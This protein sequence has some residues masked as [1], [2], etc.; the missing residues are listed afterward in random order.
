MS[1][2]NQC[3]NGYA[4][5]VP[6]P[7]NE[8]STTSEYKASPVSEV[9]ISSPQ[10]KITASGFNGY[11][12]A[13][14]SSEPI[15][16][17]GDT[18]RATEQACKPRFKAPTWVTGAM[19]ALKIKLSGWDESGNS[20]T[21]CGSGYIRVVDGEAF[22]EDSLTLNADDLYHESVNGLIG[23]PICSDHIAVSDE[24]GKVHSQKP[25]QGQMSVIVGNGFTSKWCQMD[26]NE[27][28]LCKKGVLEYVDEIEEIGFASPTMAT[29]NGQNQPV[30]IDPEGTRCIKALCGE[31]ISITTKVADP[32]YSVGC[33]SSNCGEDGFRYVTKRVTIA[34]LKA[35]LESA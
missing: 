18:A 33:A 34:E 3:E 12:P 15:I 26:Y 5:G 9:K 30:G 6:F 2:C 35:L 1:E 31:G 25:K 14:E 10:A 8:T 27:L 20:S 11:V 24:N 13:T 17:E 21:L 4:E 28:P 19:C 22:L 29:V 7:S 32:A 23:E 16:F